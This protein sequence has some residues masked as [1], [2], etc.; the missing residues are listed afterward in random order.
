MKGGGERE[1]CCAHGLM[2]SGHRPQHQRF[3]WLSHENLKCKGG[4]T[5]GGEQCSQQMVLSL[6]GR[7]RSHKSYFAKGGI[8]RKKGVAL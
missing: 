4:T 6:R 3:L 8:R 7:G 1:V 5:R 2:A